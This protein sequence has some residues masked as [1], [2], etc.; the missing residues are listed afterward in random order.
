MPDGCLD[1][2]EEKRIWPL[3]S[4][5][6]DSDP[7]REVDLNHTLGP[8]AKF[9]IELKLFCAEFRTLSPKEKKTKGRQ[10]VSEDRGG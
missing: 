5:F 3:L 4:T 1:V 2:R 6:S 7:R 9:S 8:W 10:S